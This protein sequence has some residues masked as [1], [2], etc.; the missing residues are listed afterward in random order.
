MK[1]GMWLNIAAVG[2]WVAS[3]VY[4]IT[5]MT[6]QPF[7][8][9]PATAWLAAYAIYG[10]AMALFLGLPAM[11]PGACG[12]HF[13]LVLALTQSVTGLGLNYV[14]G[15]YFGGTGVTIGLLIIVAAELPYILPPRTVWVWIA[16]QTIISTVMFIPAARGF[17][18]LTLLSFGVAMGGFQIFAVTSSMLLRREQASREQLAAANLE[19]HSTRAL[20]AE[21]SRN[22]ERLRI[23]R[24]LHDTLGHHLTALSLQLDVASR[25]TEGKAADHVRQAHAITRLLLADVRDVVSTLR[26]TRQIDLARDM[27]ALAEEACPVA[28]HLEMPPTL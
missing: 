3:G 8:L 25:L 1:G 11:T 24:D 6:G 12:A 18:I 7:D 20:V 2:T 15:S 9:W 26:E 5:V 17:G 16:V 23:S 10:V 28:I 13:P 14:S 4:P 19:L 27:R 21:N 22:A